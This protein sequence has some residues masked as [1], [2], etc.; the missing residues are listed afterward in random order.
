[1]TSRTAPV[2]RLFSYGTLQQ[3]DVQQALFGRPVPTIVDTLPGFRLETVRITD[4]VV[5]ATSGSDEH[6]LLR[7]GGADD[8]VAGVFLELT[9]DELRAADAYEVDD[10]TRIPVI[11]GSGARAWVYVAVQD[12]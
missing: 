4:P 1:M 12:A 11:L 3:P 8:S 5:I 10:Y 7:R 6:P 9:T 2:E